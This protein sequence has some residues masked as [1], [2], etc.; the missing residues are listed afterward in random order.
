MWLKR[1]VTNLDRL[2]MT[3]K[4]A[5]YFSISCSFY[6]MSSLQVC[7]VLGEVTSVAF[8]A[9]S[10]TLGRWM[11]CYPKDLFQ[12]SFLKW[13]NGQKWVVNDSKSHTV[14]ITIHNYLNIFNL[15]L[16][17]YR[18]W[19][20]FNSLGWIDNANNWKVITCKYFLRRFAFLW[21]FESSK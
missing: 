12:V 1:I 18:P 15:T 16:S 17:N 14:V 6:H 8:R 9:K 2:I 5:V 20:I 13:E 3:L 4:C 19:S 11:I 10:V 7:L 21:A